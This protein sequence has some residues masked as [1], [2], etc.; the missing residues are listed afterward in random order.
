M[1]PLRDQPGRESSTKS[2]DPH[3]SD[4]ASGRE[5][6]EKEAAAIRTLAETLDA[7]SFG[8]AIDLL[9]AC[10]AQVVLTG[11]G[12]SGH[13][14][15]KI[16]ATFAS[17]G[18]PAFFMHPGEALHGDLGM[19]TPSNV[20]VALS[21]S[22]ATDEVVNLLPYLTHL[23]IPLIAL[24]GKPESLLAQQADVVLSTAVDQEA[25]PLNL[26][27]TSSTTLQLALGDALAVA[28]MNRRGF[29]PEDF[30]I[31]HPLGA[32]GRRLLVRVADLM[33][34]GD[35][36]PVLSETAALHEA[37]L[38]ISSKRLGAVSLVDTE[39]R[40]TGIF[41]DGDVRRLLETTGGTLEMN[42][43]ISDFMIRN[44][45]RTAPDA[46]GVKAVDLMETYKI[47]VLPVLDDD[48]KPV[49]MIHLHDL[50]RAG[51]SP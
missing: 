34:T 32:L 23:S 38:Q 13:I 5:V 27:P 24:T 15:A 33:H 40:L 18:T 7:E 49:G 50:I 48:H 1:T 6:L 19:L 43:P 16:A 8:R 3:V 42:R 30:A 21:Q 35:E 25:C 47:T 29:T 28:L 51:I 45:K 10:K 39:G 20:V 4:L 26:A 11:M 12:K 14:A 36:N 17:T 44:P 46:L 31:R 9:I 37:I 41:C 22:G 2:P